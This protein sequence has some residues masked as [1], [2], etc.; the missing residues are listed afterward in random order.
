MTPEER[1]ELGRRLVAASDTI[2]Q[3]ARRV[4]DEAIV[5]TAHMSRRDV[6]QRTGLTAPRVQQ[7]ITR[8]RKPDAR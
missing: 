7:I 6:A 2:A 8:G 1:L 3:F 5:D 4:R